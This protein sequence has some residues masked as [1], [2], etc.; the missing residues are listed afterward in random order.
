MAR[1]KTIG[2]SL[3]TG[4]FDRPYAFG[5]SMALSAQNIDLDVIGSAEV[6]SPEMHS[7]AGLRFLDLQGDPRQQAGFLTKLGRLI[8]FYVRLITYA[9]TARQKVFHILWN[10][11]VQLFDRTLLMLYY[12]MLGKKIVFTAHNV[13]AGKRDGNDSALNRLTLKIQYRLCDHIFVHTEKMKSELLEDFGVRPGAV[14]VIPFGIN[15][16]LP[17]TDLTSQQARS[18]LGIAPG[19]KAMLFFGAIRP[20]K[21]LEHL[22]AALQKLARKDSKVRLIIAGEAKKGSEQYMSDVRKLIDSDPSRERIIEKIEF[23][24]DSETELYFKAADVSVLPYTLVFQSGV[25]FLSY[26]FGLPVV[27][28]DVGSF[29]DDVTDGQNGFLYDPEDPDGLTRALGK[30]FASDLYQQLEARR[31]GIRDA[32]EKAHSW[33]TVGRTTRAVYEGLLAQ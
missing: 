19:E 2:V 22:V 1:Q 4:G 29:R 16:S 28:A 18:R 12:R 8:M 24:P 17:A 9:A 5:I 26:S 25:M 20:Y 15:N 3:L 33:D 31:D 21:G 10:S 11:K 23:I 27:A 7:T 13:N 6:D 30:Y 32:A 14:T